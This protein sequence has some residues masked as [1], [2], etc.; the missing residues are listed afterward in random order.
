MCW[1]K[2][3]L[4]IKVLAWGAVLNPQPVRLAT[5]VCASSCPIYSILIQFP[6]HGLGKATEV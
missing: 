6:T 2:K 4:K 5:R 3:N 1:L